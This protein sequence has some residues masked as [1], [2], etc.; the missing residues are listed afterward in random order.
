MNN[1]AVNVA[2]LV[3]ILVSDKKK[4]DFLFSLNSV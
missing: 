4:T 3:D 1:I 2:L